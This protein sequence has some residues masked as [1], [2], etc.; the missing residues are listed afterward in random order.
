MN[1]DDTNGPKMP[2]VDVDWNKPHPDDEAV[3]RFAAAMKSKLAAKRE[4][5]RGG[6]DDN[7]KCSQKFLSDLLRGHIDKGDPLDVAN[8]AMM[9]HQRGEA[10]APESRQ[11][12]PYVVVG[13]LKSALPNQAQLERAEKNGGWQEAQING[14][15]CL[16]NAC[17]SPPFA[18]G[19]YELSAPR[20]SV[21]E[22][23]KVLLTEYLE[24]G[25]GLLG[26]LA[27]HD[28]SWDETGAEMLPDIDGDWVR[29]TDVEAALRALAGD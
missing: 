22:A 16:W 18:A 14:V 20:Q 3:D 23:A 25:E 2:R 28:I 10:I 27:C 7:A 5:G 4:E 6:W 29:F 24:H 12:L 15:D 11:P 1:I 9:L 8:F 26:E 17:V 19:E 13:K 21:Q